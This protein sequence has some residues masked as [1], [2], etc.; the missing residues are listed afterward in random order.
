MG[1]VKDVFVC[2]AALDQSTVRAHLK[3]DLGASYA[4]RCFFAPDTLAPGVLWEDFIGAQIDGCR[5]FRLYWSPAAAQSQW[6]HKECLRIRARL[7][8]GAVQFV[9]LRLGA[10]P[11]PTDFP[12]HHFALLDYHAKAHPFPFLSKPFF[13]L[14]GLMVGLV[15]PAIAALASRGPMALAWWTVVFVNLA[16]LVWAGHH[17]PHAANRTG[18]DKAASDVRNFKDWLR[19][20]TWDRPMTGDMPGRWTSTPLGGEVVSVLYW[21]WPAGVFLMTEGRI[22]SL[23][24]FLALM[25]LV[26]AATPFLV[27]ACS[28]Y[29]VFGNIYP[30]FYAL[31]FGAVLALGSMAVG[32]PGHTAVTEAIRTP[33]SVRLVVMAVIAAVLVYGVGTLRESTDREVLAAEA[34]YFVLT[35]LIFSGWGTALTTLWIPYG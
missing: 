30:A 32:M 23:P 13:A 9:G 29:P 18:V 3:H 7:E 8:A 2:H 28:N 34:R 11:S 10:V 15:V 14:L 35:I 12:R 31:F 19:E 5:E 17:I 21:L 25:T 16:H 20:I 24:L 26:A 22:T 27:A 6:V 1:V 4:D 33:F